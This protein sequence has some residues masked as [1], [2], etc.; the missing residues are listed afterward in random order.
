[1]TTKQHFLTFL[2][3]MDMFNIKSAK[4]DF[5]YSVSSKLA[6]IK[7]NAKDYIASP[8]LYHSV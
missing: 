4:L 8:V 7:R 6:A 3:A 2:I 1:M 5:C